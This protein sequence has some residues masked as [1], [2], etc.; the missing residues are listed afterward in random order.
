M[1]IILIED[2]RV[3]TLEMLYPGLFSAETNYL[4][5]PRR[6]TLSSRQ[7]DLK[8]EQYLDVNCVRSLGN[9]RSTIEY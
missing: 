8:A 1:Q 5:S 6:D 4:Y 9:R 7:G 3:L 2:A